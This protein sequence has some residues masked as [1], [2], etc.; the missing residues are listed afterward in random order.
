MSDSKNKIN[1]NPAKNPPGKFLTLEGIEGVGKSTNMSFISAFLQDKGIDHVLTREP[2]GT[3]LAE[4]I[5]GLLLNK[6][7]EKISD[8]TELLMMF[9]ARSQHLENFILPNLKAGTWVLCD[10]FTDSSFAYQGGGRR[11]EMA[12]LESLETI[13]QGDLRPDIVFLLDAP[14]ETGLQRVLERGDKDR[15]EEE[16]IEFFAR[17]RKVYLQRAKQFPERFRVIDSSADIASVQEKIGEEL[18]HFIARSCECA[19]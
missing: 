10:R 19:S 8:T 18:N 2:G 4:E 9:A 12:F 14:I 16:T 1:V 11:I 7:A 17:V 13:V 15:F 5:R 3:K 6:K